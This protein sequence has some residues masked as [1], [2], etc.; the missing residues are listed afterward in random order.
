[1]PFY[2]SLPQPRIGTIRLHHGWAAPLGALLMLALL[3]DSMQNILIPSLKVLARP[4][5]IIIS[6]MVIPLLARRAGLFD[7]ILGAIARRA[8]G[9]GRKLFF[10][11][12]LVGVLTGAIFTN[13]AAVLI[14]TPLV[15]L[16]SR[17][18]T[19]LKPVPY[20]FAVLNIAN[21]VCRLLLE[22]KINLGD[23]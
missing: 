18:W 12:F 4:I 6:L 20:L 15:C 23:A 22:K 10:W 5:V 21:L 1:M 14:L 7:W 11:L 19:G 2:L 17:T 16:M 3:P 13:D 8:K 9:D